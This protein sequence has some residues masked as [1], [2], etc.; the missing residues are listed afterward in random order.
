MSSR[1]TAI[2]F[3]KFLAIGTLN[4]M[5]DFGTLNAPPTSDDAGDGR[6]RQCRRAS[7]HRRQRYF[8]GYSDT[9]RA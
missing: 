6:R 5:I 8:D 4:T 3:G 9:K 1:S 2:Q 7:D